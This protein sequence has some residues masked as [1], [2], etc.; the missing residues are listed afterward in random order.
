MTSAAVAV[1]LAVWRTP[2]RRATVAFGLIALVFAYT[3]VANVIERPDGV[4]IAAFFIAA[5]VVVSLLSRIWRTTELRVGKITLDA[6]AKRFIDE[7]AQGQT[8]RIVANEPRRCDDSEYVRREREQREDNGIPP[9]EKVVFLEIYVPDG[10]E[11]SADLNVHGVEVGPHH[12]LRA[13]S[14]AVA[15]GI[16][17]FLLY[18]RDQTGKVPH[19]YFNWSEGNPVLYLIRYVLSGHGEVAPITREVL[20]EAEPNPA[21]RPR[22][23]AAI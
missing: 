15:N 4:K 1:T 17:A 11:F 10:S 3:T 5:I 13:E 2:A 18:L 14:A 12:V 16:A 23:H 19:A 6:T 8:L 9:T 21:R 22:I 20:R 7:A